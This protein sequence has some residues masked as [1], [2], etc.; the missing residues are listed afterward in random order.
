MK[1]GVAIF[2]LLIGVV[3]GYML[4]GSGAEKA[5]E[6][7]EAIHTA[8]EIRNITGDV[9]EIGLKIHGNNSTGYDAEIS[10]VNF[11]LTPEN[12]S[13]E[14]VVGEGHAHIY[15]DG[16]KINRVYGEWYHLG[17]FD[18]GSHE[19]EVRLSSNDHHELAVDDVYI[20][21][22]TIIVVRDSTLDIM[23]DHPHEDGEEDDHPH[24]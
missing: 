15:A 5:Y 1:K 13:G 21:T 18:A 16:V 17:K 4:G 10:F 9:P 20:R 7:E 14:G 2:I 23:D 8:H 19:I 6:A 22:N 12:A 3:F 24:E 11:K